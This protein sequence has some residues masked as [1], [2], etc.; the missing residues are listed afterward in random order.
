M[1]VFGGK[2]G[3]GGG[4][5]GGVVKSVYC[6]CGLHDCRL[7]LFYLGTNYF[8]MWGRGHYDNLK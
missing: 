3:G 7:S 2:Q 1:S 4:G 5:G 8:L 6:G